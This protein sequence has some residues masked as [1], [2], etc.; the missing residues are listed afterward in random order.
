M[1]NYASEKSKQESWH[2]GTIYDGEGQV[3]IQSKE[4]S[5]L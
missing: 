1:M 2:R 5:L 4:S 3:D